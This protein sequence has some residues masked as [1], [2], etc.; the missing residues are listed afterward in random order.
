MLKVSEDP[1]V[2]AVY[3]DRCLAE[4]DAGNALLV[5]LKAKGHETSS[6][7]KRAAHYDIDAEEYFG[8]PGKIDVAI[9]VPDLG[10]KSQTLGIK[11]ALPWTWATLSED[12]RKDYLA[13]I[14]DDIKSRIEVS[15]EYDQN[16]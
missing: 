2:Q 14:A 11:L 9:N 15:A 4:E 13:Y 6:D 5:C 1:R 10:T 8:W 16:A 7:P 12:E 3:G